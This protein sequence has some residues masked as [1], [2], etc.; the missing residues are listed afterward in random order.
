MDLSERDILLGQLVLARGLIS[1]PTLLQSVHAST[2]R[3]VA[4]GEELGARGALDEE[5]LRGLQR[6]LDRPSPDL[7]HEIAQ[8]HTLVL[9]HATTSLKGRSTEEI[10]ES[11]LLPLQITLGA[12]FAP[13]QSLADRP[14]ELTEPGAQPRS[15]EEPSE[16]AR[17]RIDGLLG[18][19]GMGH[20]WLAHD[21][22]LNREVALKTVRLNHEE[23]RASFEQQLRLEAQITGM[24]EHPS[25]VPVYDLGR[26]A[27][28][29]LYYTMRVVREE[30]LEQRLERMRQ[31][32]EVGT[33][34]QLLGILRTALL[35]LQYAHDHGIVHRDLKPENI[36]IGAYGEV[37]IIDWGVAKVTE[38]AAS[39]QRFAPT[40]TKAG[41][42]VGTPHYMAPE[43]ALG[44]NERVDERTDVYAMGAI[45]YETLTLKKMFE[46]GHVLALLLKVTEEPPVPPSQRAS[47]HRVPQELE[48]ICLKAIEKRQEARYASAQQMAREIELFLEGVKERE[49]HQEL[50]QR[51]LKQA[52]EERRA[53]QRV[54]Q[55]RRS[56]CELLEAQL[57]ALPTWASASQKE[58]AWLLEQRVEQLELELE[59]H[60][61]EALR[62][63]GQALGYVPNHGL[64]RRGMAELYWQ[65]FLR[66]EQR[67]D[68]ANAIYF[69][70]LVRQYNDG[71]Y[72]T[73]LAGLATLS[74]RCDRGDAVYK[75]YRYEKGLHRLRAMHQLTG[76]GDLINHRVPHGSYLLTIEAPG[77]LPL[78]VP[79]LLRRLSHQ[80]L[81]LELLDDEA[82]PRDLVVVTQGEFLSGALG[83]EQSG[84]DVRRLPRF[85]IT[86]YP[87][88]CGEY[89]AF[90]NDLAQAEG[91]ERARDHAPR[92]SDEAE[93]YF[94]FDPARG[95]F[96]IPED[97]GEGTS[98]EASWPIVLVTYADAEAYAMWRSGRDGLSYQV[99][100]ALQ[101]EKAARGVDGRV[102]VWGNEFDP[103][104]CRMRE[105][106]QGRPLPASIHSYP[107]DCSPYGVMHLNG[108]VIEW[109]SSIDDEEAGTHVMRG[110]SY[111]S[112]PQGCRLDTHLSSPGGFRYGSYGFRLAVDLPGDARRS[113]APLS[114]SR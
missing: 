28:H 7:E 26:I 5:T 33:L 35:A 74:M 4:L 21:E 22:L 83:D 34:N 48:E 27:S 41:A 101:L 79:L 1:F 11:D 96:F 64:A 42:L 6:D 45:L 30:S 19:G 89:V 24:L 51:L 13:S 91:V 17:Y 73:L 18:Q 53:Y 69:E 59:R 92:V 23:D 95:G 100:S 46:A 15:A 82:L 40:K 38:R 57:A 12:P 87:V 103:S 67:G 49:R 111:S 106:E 2:R 68:V 94:P 47:P 80:E 102:Y 77:A 58:P 60:F 71:Q 84:Q 76:Q 44:E 55:Q 93:S 3:G 29:G 81:N 10:S 104:F 86:R 25:I 39:L 63:Y 107:L 16:R 65:R 75:L 8:G 108:N 72:N 32:E 43:Q 56:A 61:G 114:A 50:A 99:P 98:W 85:A 36:L 90:L 78:R 110:A 62:Y 112:A 14:D 109:S 20:V 66:A 9:R 70:G 88:T 31:G 54:H 37:F 113:A 52:T 105:S 97:D